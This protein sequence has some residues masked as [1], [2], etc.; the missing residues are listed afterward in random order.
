MK[1]RIGIISLFVLLFIAFITIWNS[2]YQSGFQEAYVPVTK[3]NKA[4]EIPSEAGVFRRSKYALEYANAPVDKAHQRSLSTY[5]NNRA[6]PGAPPTIPHPILRDGVVGGK[7][8]LKCHDN[9]G[10]VQKY[11]AYAPVTPH[12]ELT[13]CRQCHV[14]VKT[15]TNFKVNSFYKMP[16][17]QAGVNKALL[18][19]PPMIPHAIKMREN[20]LAC[21]AGPNA[22]KEIRVSHPERVNCRQCHVPTNKDAVHN[23]TFKRA[24]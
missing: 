17:P 24:N 5:Y 1:K 20:C 7:D 21:H 23:G 16:A 18:T 22:P 6:Y 12:P 10:F 19:S 14:P 13:N 9:G 2:S 11:N 3:E 8:C 4:L 15:T